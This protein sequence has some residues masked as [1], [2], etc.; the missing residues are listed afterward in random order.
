MLGIWFT[1]DFQYCELRNLRERKSK[2]RALSKIWLETTP[3][4]RAAVLKSLILAENICLRI[5]LPYP[6]DNLFDALRKTVSE[7]VWN[8]K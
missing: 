3:L 2:R 8:K 4:G 7:F 6:P 1:N 5:L